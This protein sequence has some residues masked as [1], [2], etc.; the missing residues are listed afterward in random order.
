[1]SGKKVEFLIPPLTA[2]IIRHL[3]ND[4]G[5]LECQISEYPHDFVGGN[6]GDFIVTSIPLVE[7]TPETDKKFLADKDLFAALYLIHFERDSMGPWV[8]LEALISKAF[9]CGREFELSQ[10]GRESGKRDDERN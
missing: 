6:E 9:K 3:G 8:I 7:D 2:H 1:M 4:A 10:A 5:T